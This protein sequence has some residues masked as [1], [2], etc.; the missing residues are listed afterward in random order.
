MHWYPVLFNIT[1]R[2]KGKTSAGSLK[3]LPTKRATRI[4][5]LKVNKLLTQIIFWTH[6]TI[7]ALNN[8]LKTIDSVDHNNS[9]FTVNLTIFLKVIFERNQYN[10]DSIKF[11]IDKSWW[12]M[13][14]RRWLR[15]EM[16][17]TE[18]SILIWM[19]THS[20]FLAIEKNVP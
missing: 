16:G 15:Y 14:N 18:A 19:C 5:L 6:N 3:L 11:L 4:M 17:N 8:L 20:V 7:A 2:W 9:T 12:N 13:P 1:H 10:M